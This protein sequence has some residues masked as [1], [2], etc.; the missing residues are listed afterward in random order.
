VLDAVH[1]LG[2]PLAE[3]IRLRP[4]LP[5]FFRRLCARIPIIAAAAFGE[6]GPYFSQF[7]QEL[8]LY[9][10]DFGLRRLVPRPDLQRLDAVLKISDGCRI[11]ITLHVDGRRMRARR[12]VAL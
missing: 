10:L 9:L 3:G 12:K 2:V 11:L 1:Q 8:S 6:G 7:G 5:E 4:Q